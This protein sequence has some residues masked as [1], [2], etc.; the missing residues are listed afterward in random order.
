VSE[1]HEDRIAERI[2]SGG[3]LF[4]GTAALGD[5]EL[6]VRHLNRCLH[7]SSLPFLD[8]LNLPDNLFVFPTGTVDAHLGVNFL[9]L[10]Q[11]HRERGRKRVRSTASQRHTHARGGRVKAFILALSSSS[12]TTWS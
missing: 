7:R 5:I 1:P 6:V 3:C 9:L 12:S 11:N 8:R 10:S 4:F 2:G